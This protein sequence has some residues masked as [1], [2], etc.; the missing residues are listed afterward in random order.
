AIDKEKSIV[1]KD[2]WWRSRRGARNDYGGDW[3]WGWCGRRRLCQPVQRQPEPGSG[4]HGLPPRR[5]ARCRRRG[6]SESVPAADPVLRHAE[7]LLLGAAAKRRSGRELFGCMPERG[8]LWERRELRHRTEIHPKEWLLLG[9]LD[10]R[11]A[12]VG[13][14]EP[15]WLDGVQRLD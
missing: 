11:H 7:R 13:V 2:P 14:G 3:P 10:R 5:Q 4:R 6:R 1:R 15:R 9:L 8:E 12:V